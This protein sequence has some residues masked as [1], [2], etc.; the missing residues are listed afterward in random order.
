MGQ[1][2]FALPILVEPPARLR[3]QVRGA[4]QGV[5]FRPFLYREARALGLTGFAVNTP[6]GV[7]LEVEGAPAAIERLRQRILYAPP[8]HAHI[9]ALDQESLLPGGDSDFEIRP[10]QYQCE[11][12]GAAQA[13][14]LPDL[15]MCRECRE[16]IYSPGNR[17]YRYPFTNC[18]Q[19]GPRFSILLDLPYDRA[20]TSMRGFV[21]CA[22]CAAEYHDPGNRRFHAEPN[23]C[24]ICGPRLQLWDGAG[25]RRAE[26]QGV[27]AEGEA[28]LGQVT[29]ALRRGEIV[30]VKGLGG[31]HLLVDA[32]DPAA[33]RRL[34]TR[35]LRAEKPFAVMFPSLAAVH[36]VC[37]VSPVEAALLTGPQA[38]IVLLKR[39]PRLHWGRRENEDLAAEVAPR[40]PRLG[41]LLPYTPLHQLLLADL[42]FPLVATSGNGAEEPIAIDEHEARQRL[43]GIADLFLVHNRPILRPLDDSLV[44]V[45]AGRPQIL[46]RARGYA[47]LPLESDA[48]PGILALG[49]HLKSSLALGTAAGIVA[50]PHLGDLDTAAARDGYAR[51]ASEL[52]RLYRLRPRLAVR[53]LHPDYYSSRFAETLAETLGL[54]VRAVQ[55]HVAHVWSC[56]AEHAVEPPVLGVAF[57]GSGY[58]ADGTLWGGEFLRITPTG[59]RRVA[60]LR[61]FRLP[62]GTAALREPRRAAL[63]LLAA[64]FGPESLEWTDL[65]PVAAFTPAERKLLAAMLARGVNAPVTTAA[66]RLFDAVAALIGLRQCC[67]YEGQAATE[68]EAAANADGDTEPDAAYDFACRPGTRPEDPRVVD[69]EPALRALL[70]DFRGGATSAAMARRFHAGLAAAIGVVAVRIGEPK[71]ALSGGCFQ[72]VRLTELTLQALRAAGFTP[73]WHQC[74]PPNDGGLAVGQAAWAAHRETSGET[75]CV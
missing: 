18:T 15:A 23:A 68:L 65:P 70:R 1:E 10:S 55:H 33:V 28:A 56:M 13:T 29:Q 20:R 40:N 26:G 57:D 52:T 27:L 46:R 17:R 62:G 64:A 37:R 14:V 4:V 60:H 48:A 47:P 50:G 21:M 44:Q 3:F 73:Y 24:P 42:D 63:G 22:A 59:W 19:C 35:K 74:V 6:E 53:D 71:V 39:L 9:T 67:G 25:A 51:S 16:E 45:V 54:P 12:E 7:S 72:N 43:G 11:G 5:G 49:G 8:P 34:R 41:V 38:P 31:F 66:G 32:R 36:K 69:W 58:G 2:T 30:A 61:S 75:P